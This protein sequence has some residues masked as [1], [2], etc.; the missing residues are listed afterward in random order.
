[1]RK[2]T[3][4]ILAAVLAITLTGCR[5]RKYGLEKYDFGE[6]TMD[7]P[8]LQTPKPGDTIAIIDT[9]M[10]EI[11]VKLFP[12]YAPNTVDK[13][14]NLAKE[15]KYDNI[16]IP[17]V[18]PD[19]LFLTAGYSM[20]DG[21]FT[22]LENESELIEN[23]LS[24]EIWPFRGALMSYSEVEGKS[25]ARWFMCNVDKENLTKSAIDELKGNTWKFS[26]EETQNKVN[27][28]LDKF[29]EYGGVF[30]FAGQA[31][32]FGQT[33][34]GF[35]VVEKLTNIPA[36]SE[37]GLV[38]EI[39]HIKS[40]K[41]SEFKSGDEVEDFPPYVHEESENNSSTQ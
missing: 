20:G 22:G 33:Y 11:R 26:E 19:T 34:K 9:D 1:M 25:D 10:G 13:F 18:Y 8:Q 14:I 7:F 37:T 31:T 23:E 30:G 35:D 38:T 40:V 2:F 15:G 36:D 5:S 4:A 39:H 6:M 29:Y 24:A 28:L 3:A 27:T 16:P 32:V 21:K 17:T 12:E 41:I